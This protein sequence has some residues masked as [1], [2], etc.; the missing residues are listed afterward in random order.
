M[1]YLNFVSLAFL[2][3]SGH[4]RKL[5]LFFD[6]FCLFKEKVK[7]TFPEIRLFTHQLKTTLYADI[8]ENIT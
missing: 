1:K 4:L 3:I 6:F 8:Y 5:Y 2:D 7:Q